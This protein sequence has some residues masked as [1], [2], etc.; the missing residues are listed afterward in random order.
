MW[1]K[2]DPRNEIAQ[3]LDKNVI[4]FNGNGEE[5]K[6]SLNTYSAFGKDSI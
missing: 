2:K 6:F 5:N 4:Y 1:I 3:Q